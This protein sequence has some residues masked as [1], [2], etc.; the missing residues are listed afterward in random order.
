MP[1]RITGRRAARRTRSG[2]PSPYTSTEPAG[3]RGQRR[4]ADAASGHGASGNG[5]GIGGHGQVDGAGALGDGR[6]QRLADD[7][8]GRGRI[9][10]QRQLGDRGEQ[11]VVIDHLVGEELLA[12]TLDLAGDRQHRHP[13][14]GRRGHAV[15]HRRRPGPQGG[16]AGSGQAGHHRRRLG[17]EGGRALPHRGHHLD[18]LVAGRL[19]E[20]DDRTRRDSRR[21]AARRPRA[22]RRPAGPPWNRALV[23]K[24]TAVPSPHC[25]RT[26]GGAATRIVRHKE[27][28]RRIRRAAAAGRSGTAC[29][30][31]VCRLR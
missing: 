22:G 2:S 26:V 12:G 20:V 31:E 21:R 19:H 27:R 3:G 17:H 28:R 8:V 11:P 24:Q 13:V 30:R 7:G 6:A 18:A 25:P 5:P 10:A 4:Q 23:Q 9:Q 14:Q 16:Q 15:Q 29:R 1:A